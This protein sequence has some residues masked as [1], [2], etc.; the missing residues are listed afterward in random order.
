MAFFTYLRDKKLMANEPQDKTSI[1][2]DDLLQ[3]VLGMERMPFSQLQ[4]TLLQRNAIV[5]VTEP[6]PVKVTYVMRSVRDEAGEEGSTLLPPPWQWDMECSIPHLYP[7]RTRELLR[8][9]KR[10][11]LEYTS[12]R[13]RAR[14]LLSAT[15]R[16]NHSTEEVRHFVESAV[17]A[18][19]HT[20]P[21]VVW[22]ALAKG[23]PPQTE[24]RRAAQLEA[25]WAY[26]LQEALPV[27]LRGA[28]QA[29]ELV[30]LSVRESL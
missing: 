3:E 6:P 15:V 23:A 26:L 27:S 1:L 21:Q 5:R 13:T 7:F 2:C 19:P 9:V 8:R 18:E 28:M 30:D 29:D 11:E 22:Q 12:S 20:V 25:Q 17:Q 4:P 14:Y 24:A 10:R 16:Q